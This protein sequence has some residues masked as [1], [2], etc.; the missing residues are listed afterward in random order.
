MAPGLSLPVWPERASDVPPPAGPNRVQDDRTPTVSTGWGPDAA[1][2][3][4]DGVP[5]MGSRKWPHRDNA[6]PAPGCGPR[7]AGG[8]PFDDDRGGREVVDASGD[9]RAVYEDGWLRFEDASG[10]LLSRVA[11]TFADLVQGDC[12][13]PA[14]RSLRGRTFEDPRPGQAAQDHVRLQRGAADTATTSLPAGS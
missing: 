4:V 10:R 11:T 6:S 2:L 3:S 7:A 14:S 1:L 9:V 5:C 8:Q 12:A 13:P